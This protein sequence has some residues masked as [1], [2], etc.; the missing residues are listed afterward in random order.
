MKNM[1][2]LS[3]ENIKDLTLQKIASKSLI[4]FA[5][6][7]D[8]RY[9]INWHH[10]VIANELQGAYENVQRGER[11][12]IILEIPPRHGK[13]DLSTIKF[14]AWVLGKSPELPIIVTSYAADLAADFGL[15]TKD[16]MNSQAYQVIFDTRLR[17][18]A[19]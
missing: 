8:K 17:D 12:R 5:D 9:K 13:S 14:P 4:D 7:T 1:Q 15:A 3:P 16:L 18:D 11:A 6:I 10:E 2:Q 19:K